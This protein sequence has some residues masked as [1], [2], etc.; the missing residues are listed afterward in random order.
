MLY[1]RWREAEV[2]GLMGFNVNCPVEKSTEKPKGPDGARW[3]KEY[4]G[5]RCNEGGFAQIGDV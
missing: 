5:G 3:P 1:L 2:L 4:H